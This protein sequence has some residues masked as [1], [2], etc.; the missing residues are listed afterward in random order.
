MSQDLTTLEM[1]ARGIAIGALLAMAAGFA[2]QAARTHVRLTG[3][4]FSLSTVAYALNS[5]PNIMQALGW[6]TYPV[7]FMALAGAGLFWL[8]IVTLFEDRPLDWRGFLPWA[9]L[10]AIGLVGIATP[11]PAASAIWIVHNLIEAGLAAHALYVVARSWRGDLVESRRRLRGPF[12]ALVTLYVLTLSAFEI[13]ES[14]GFFYDWFRL[15]GAATLALYCLAGAAVFLEARSELFG[16]PTPARAHVPERLDAGDRLTLDKL[17]VAMAAGAWRREGLTIGD[18][19][20]E[21]GAPEHRLRPLIN[22]HLGFRNFAG[23]INA[24]RIEAAKTVLSDPAQARTTIAAIAFDL[25]FG[26]LGPFNR[27]FKDVTGLTPSEF[28]RGQTSPISE[29]PR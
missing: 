22:D 20:A 14:L 7:H 29:N 17:N 19:A 12:L 4:L 23:F 18:L 15:L 13:A 26:S 16:A 10:T 24:A 28:R 25:G 6:F 3:V 5:S 21:V 2:R 8:F 27:A 11:R 1:V 9:L